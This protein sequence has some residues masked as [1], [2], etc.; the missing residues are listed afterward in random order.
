M[1]AKERAD[2]QFMQLVTSELL[3][4]TSGMQDGHWGAGGSCGGDSPRSL[5]LSQCMDLLH[6]SEAPLQVSSN[7]HRDGW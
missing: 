5:V 6:K 7:G 1:L 2:S 3:S 4:S